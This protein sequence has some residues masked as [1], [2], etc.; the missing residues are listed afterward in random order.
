MFTSFDKFLASVI[1]PAIS[2]GILNFAAP[3]GISGSTTFS[4]IISIAI[5][6]ALVYFVPNKK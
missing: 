6:A 2:T 4:Q 5:G 3:L 1:G